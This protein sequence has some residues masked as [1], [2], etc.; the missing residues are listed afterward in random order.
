MKLFGKS[1]QELNPLIKAGTGELN[2]LAKEA[3]DVGAVMSDESVNSAG[4][5][6]D[7][8]QTLQASAQG[9][10]SSIGVAVM[11][12]IT[13]IVSNVSSLVPKITK[14]VQ[15]GNWDEVANSISG[16]LTSLIGQITSV[17]PGLI[18]AA[19]AI[20]S[21]LIKA[22]VQSLPVILPALIDGILMLLDA[23]IQ[24][25]DENGEMIIGA[26]IKAVLTLAI[27][28]IKAVPKLI[29]AAI[30]IIKGLAFGI[31]DNL[32]MLIEE[33]PKLVEA[34]VKGIVDNLP[35]LLEAAIQIMVALVVAIIQNLPKLLE[36][37]IKIIGSLVKGIVLGI[38]QLIE[39]VPKMYV[40]FRD[41][42]QTINWKQ[43]GVNMI[44][45]IAEGIKNAAKNIGVSII[46]AAKSALDAAK[47]FLGIHSPSSVMRDQVGKMIGEGMAE[48]IV[49]TSKSV[50]SAMTNLNKDLVI[51]GVT[52]ISANGSSKGSL[53]SSTVNHTGT[54]TVKGVNDRGQTMAVVDIV[55]EELRRE[56]RLA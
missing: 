19:V 34:I 33:L 6:D 35:I 11:P 39:T 15:T 41:K 4:K 7:M 43:L 52:N 31:I 24:I 36:A 20:I 37:G 16:M 28:L 18:K 40:A 44:N 42:L 13:G 45:G 1:A 30:S 9:L 5:F 21:Q 50:K 23:V 38:T 22:L 2:R 29:P 26:A 54:I 3:N 49:G 46:D 17:L 8:L 47:K 25:L 48:G 10:A 56:A 55:M 14:A 32:P 27:G 53:G 51:N 12:A